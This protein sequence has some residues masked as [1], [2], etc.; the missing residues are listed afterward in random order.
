MGFVSSPMIGMHRDQQQ[1]ESSRPKQFLVR[2]A[3]NLI[4]HN[5]YNLSDLCTL[6]IDA[7]I[8]HMREK[9]NLKTTGSKNSPPETACSI[10]LVQLLFMS[11]CTTELGAESSEK[12]LRN[13]A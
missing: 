13:H 7:Y 6:Q 3:Q 1:H 10:A 8:T 4:I 12:G 5:I 2:P 11:R 9:N